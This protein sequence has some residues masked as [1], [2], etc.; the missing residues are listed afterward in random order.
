M[1]V[2]KDRLSKLKELFPDTLQPRYGTIQDV[3]KAKKLSEDRERF[4]LKPEQILKVG[5][6]RVAV[7][8]QWGKHNI[9]GFVKI[10]RSLGYNIK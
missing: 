6:K 5:D 8:N 10:A 1:R 7:C 9:G 3:S 2:A 4:F